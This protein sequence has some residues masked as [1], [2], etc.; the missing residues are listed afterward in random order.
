MNV[1]TELLEALNKGKKA[2]VIT[3]YENKNNTLYKNSIILSEE[4]ILAKDVSNLNIENPHAISACLEYGSLEFFQNQETDKATLMEPYF[5]EPKLIVFGGGHI[6]KPLVEFA[7]KV[8]FHITVI[9]DRPTFANSSRFPEAE[10]VICESFEKSFDLIDLNQS[11]FV[12]IITRGHRHDMLCLKQ[13]LKYETSYVGMIG[14]KRRTKIAKEQLS[15][16]GYSQEHINKINAPIGL[17]IDAV[18]PEEIAIS[19]VAQLISYRRRKK[20]IP[21]STLPQKVN[22]PEFDHVVIKELAQPINKPK[23]IV[24]IIS[25]KGS[26]PRKAGAKMIVYGD[27]KILGSI[28]GGCSEGEVITIA[29]GIIKTG[30]YIVHDVDMTGYIAEDEGMVCGGIMKVLIESI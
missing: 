29:R 5:P 12:V 22:N 2:V 18:S 21:G 13:T 7:S 24:T 26:V 14:S 10:K 25:T 16:E 19:I 4:A 27:G 8:G 23:A 3:T 30:G 15:D 9:D 6:A 28:G 17:D 20:V 11:S 1:Y